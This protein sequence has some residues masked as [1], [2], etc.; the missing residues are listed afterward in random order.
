MIHGGSLSDHQPVGIHQ[1]REEFILGGHSFEAATLILNNHGI[2]PAE[3]VVL[4]SLLT[5]GRKTRCHH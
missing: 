2:N 3:V 1:P 4:W 5:F